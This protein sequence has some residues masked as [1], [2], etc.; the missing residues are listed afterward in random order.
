[1][2]NYLKVKEFHR[3]FRVS[4]GEEPG[5]LDADRQGLRNRLIQEEF[6]EYLEAVEEGDLPNI[7]KEL[8]D[9]LYVVYGTA[10]EHGIDIDK[11]FEAVHMSNLSKLAKCSEC[12]QSTLSFRAYLNIDCQN[13]HNTGLVPIMRQDGK[14]LKSDRYTPPDIEK[15]LGLDK[16]PVE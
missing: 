4:V 13:C 16:A 9:L 10:V 7:A 8:A 1:M 3:L 6:D 15:V 11:V 2:S 14:V 5:F 12:E